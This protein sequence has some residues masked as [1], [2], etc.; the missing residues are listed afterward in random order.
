M[1]ETALPPTMRPP[2]WRRSDALLAAW[3][4]VATGLVTRLVWVNARFAAAIRRGA[5]PVDPALTNLLNACRSEVR[6]RR[7]V[8]L[9]V[10]QAVEAPAACGIVRPRVL[11]PVELARS[12]PDDRLRFVFLHE[13]AHVRSYDVAIDCVWALVGA[14]HWFNPVLWLIAPLRRNDRELARDEQVLTLT[15]RV[16]AESYGRALLDLSQSAC[17]APFCPGLVGMFT[18]RAPLRRRVEAVAR[19]SGRR[20][21][22]NWAGIALLIGAASCTLTTAPS[23]APSAPTPVAPRLVTTTRATTQLLS[24]DDPD[25]PSPATLATLEQLE[26][27]IRVLSFHDAPLE[28]VIDRLRDLADGNIYVDWAGLQRAGVTRT[29]RVT[30]R[31]RDVK[32]GKALELVF[33]SVENGNNDGD[34][35]GYV[36]DEGIVTISSRR[37]LNKNTVTRRYDINDLLFVAPDYPN[38]RDLPDAQKREELVA[39]IVK[40]IEQNVEPN[41]WVDAGGEVGSISMSPLRA[42][43]LITQTPDN[44]RKIRAVLDSLRGSQ[45]M[46]VSVQVRVVTVSDADVPRVLGNAKPLPDL[47][48][49]PTPELSLRGSLLSRAAVGTLVAAAGPGSTT[50][51]RL[52][53]FSGQR[54]AVSAM[55]DQAYVSAYT[56]VV[57]P[58][59]A[60]AYEPIV[61]TVTTGLAF[62]V[63]ATVSPDRQSVFVDLR[64]TV[65]RLAG[66][67]TQPWAGAPAAGLVQ[68]PVVLTS[69]MRTSCSIPDGARSS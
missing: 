47:R 61:R 21:L 45:E 7:N 31:L 26:R 23:P 66:L 37:E 17:R 29:S 35:L 63:Q 57:R 19:Y 64:P 39:E 8:R 18:G 14:L 2:L 36:A 25:Q 1:P 3:L 69:A 54:S 50:A 20:R 12:A 38:T 59:N 52:T 48:Q 10:T 42:I 13:L 30:V 65:T 44:Q 41:S 49:S 34:R 6:C 16:N 56:A 58:G 40:Y 60:T 46:Q 67:V 51:P 5:H 28:A 9:V 22:A 32:L 27:K 24:E 15:G 55:T 11:L 53:L 33:R 43:L 68:R 4:A 62:E